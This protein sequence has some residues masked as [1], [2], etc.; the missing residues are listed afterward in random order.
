MSLEDRQRWDQVYRE[1]NGTYPPPDPLLFEFTPP[2][3][4]G[5]ERRGL[6]LA[7]GLGQNGLW[8]AAQGYTVD[9]MDISR[10]ALLRAQEEMGKR[11]IRTANL[12]Q[13]DLDQPELD[14][15]TYHVACVFRYLKRDLFPL[16]RACVAPGGRIIYETFNQR[17]LEVVPGFN[18]QFL[19]GVGELAGYF[20]DWK[21][22]HNAEGKHVSRIVA[23]KPVT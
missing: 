4:A 22:L 2:I 1:A 10:V 16:L 18:P 21:I 14:A 13:V 9:L 6:D 17:Y 8:L 5:E 12:F 23:V 7:C 19:L 3:S 15:N 20:A 11:A